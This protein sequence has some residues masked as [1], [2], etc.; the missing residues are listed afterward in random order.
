VIE[1]LVDCAAVAT[2]VVQTIFRLPSLPRTVP[3][4]VAALELERGL[5]RPLVRRIGP[6]ESDLL[7]SLI[8]GT[9][10]GLCG[11]FAMPAVDAVCRILL[12]GEIRARRQ[13]WERRE[14]GLCPGADCVA[15][16]RPTRHLRARAPGRPD[17][18]SGGR[19]GWSPSPRS[20]PALCWH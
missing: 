6:I 5:R 12:L 2:G 3:T 1:L 9:V 16:T 13:V 17:R 19:L 4:V 18:S 8:S 14:Q 10:N 7:L 11:G 15:P 20:P